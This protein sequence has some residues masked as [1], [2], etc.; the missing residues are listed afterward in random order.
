MSSAHTISSQFLSF[1]RLLVERGD[2]VSISTL[3]LSILYIR[4][5]HVKDLK[6]NIISTLISIGLR[7]SDLTRVIGLLDELKKHIDE[8]KRNIDLLEEI[9]EEHYHKFATAL[10]TFIKS[11]NFSYIEKYIQVLMKLEK[12]SNYKTKKGSFK[13]WLSSG[14]P[15][16]QMVRY[17]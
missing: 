7:E 5:Y 15:E 16:D 12:A 13:T 11:T 6:N 2:P 1:T 14:K 9:E 4:L 3:Y 10:Y 17:Y 8:I